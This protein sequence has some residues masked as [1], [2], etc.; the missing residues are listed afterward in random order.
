MK[1]KEKKSKKVIFIITTLSIILTI[2]I[3]FNILLFNKSNK[4]EYKNDENIIFFGDSIT[5]IYNLNKYYPKRNVV[6]KGVSGNKTTDL[7]NRINEDVYEYNPSKV[8]LLVGINDLAADTE[9]EDILENIQLIIN[10]IQ[11]NRKNSEI[12]VESVYPINKDLIMEHGTNFAYTLDNN[13]VMN[14]NNELKKLCKENDITYIDVYSKLIDENNEL[15]GNY[16]KDGIHLSDLGYLKV[17]SE[18]KKYVN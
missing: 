6:N 3:V 2:S 17:T 13:K 15:K 7:V 18:L 4:V 12:Y 16:T 10:G 9:Q 8:F 11:I 14:L 1:N 5:E